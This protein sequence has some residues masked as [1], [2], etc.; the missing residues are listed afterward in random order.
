MPNKNFPRLNPNQY[1]LTHRRS[2]AAA[3]T[4]NINNGASAT[5]FGDVGT[6][7]FYTDGYSELH[8]EIKSDV[9]LTV[10]VE[11]GE[12][13]SA[14]TQTRN[15]SVAAATP[16]VIRVPIVS[17]KAKVTVSNAS[18]GA[19]TSLRVKGWLASVASGNLSPA[20]SI[21]GT[22]TLTTGSDAAIVA[23][24]G[25]GVRTFLTDL[26]ISNTNTT[27]AM[28]VDIKDGSTIVWSLFIAA[29][30]CVVINLARALRGSPNTAWNGILTGAHTDIR[31][32]YTGYQ[33]VE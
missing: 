7:I 14:F 16:R 27:T 2:L 11:Q 4:S 31:V 33:G 15:Y 21:Q 10:K 5:P 29:N 9:A 30:G 1:E 25:A 28:R 23:A 18:G 22:V 8:I 20:D 32:N 3:Y 6:G 17:D 19:T 24:G 12:L 26:V 13:T